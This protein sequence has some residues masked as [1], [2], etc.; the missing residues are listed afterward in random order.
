MALPKEHRLQNG[1][2]IQ[3]VLRRGRLVSCPI[4]DFRYIQRNTP[5]AKSRFAFIISRQVAKSSVVRNRI[6]RRAAE[7]TRKHLPI[8]TPVVVDGVII[9]KKRAAEASRAVFYQ[10]IGPLFKKIS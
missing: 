8:T 5:R 2:E 10:E 1:R 6:R 3:W 7:W 4:A 9:F